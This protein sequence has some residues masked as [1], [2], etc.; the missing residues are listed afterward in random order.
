MKYLRSLLC[1]LLVTFIAH[2]SLALADTD[3]SVRLLV[4]K[5]GETTAKVVIDSKTYLTP[6][7]F[8]S[9][10]TWDDVKDA[11]HV[12]P[13]YASLLK[14]GRISI[15]IGCSGASFSVIKR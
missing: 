10:F 12:P 7:S 14:H 11:Y 15:F 4:S 2:S 6:I 1:L 5:S 8:E 13:A 9:G 3:D